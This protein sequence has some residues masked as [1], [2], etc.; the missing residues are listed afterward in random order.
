[1]QLLLFLQRLEIS[2]AG[3]IDLSN[4]MMFAPDERRK[5]KYPE[6][7]LLEQG[8]TGFNQQIALH[9]EI[10]SGSHWRKAGVLITEPTLLLLNNTV[11]FSL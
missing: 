2:K 7:N 11:N 4:Q 8:T 10:N 3:Q 1:M 5:P 6:K 9:P